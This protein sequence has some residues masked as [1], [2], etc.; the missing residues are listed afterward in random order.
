VTDRQTDRP[1]YSVGNNRPHVVRAMRPSSNDL[2]EAGHVSL[3]DVR[4]RTFE[5]LDDV[6]ALVEL[7]KDV[8]HRAREQDML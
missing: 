6:E 3:D 8:G 4:V 2:G 1:R 5:L 7:C